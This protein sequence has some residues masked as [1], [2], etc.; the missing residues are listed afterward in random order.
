MFWGLYMMN[1]PFVVRSTQ[2]R[3]FSC[4]GESKKTPKNTTY[5]LG[6]GRAIGVNWFKLCFIV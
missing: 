5:V 3:L 1:K 6:F 2:K 4:P